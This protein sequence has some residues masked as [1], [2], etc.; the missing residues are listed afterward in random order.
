M[1]YKTDITII[2]AGIIGLAIA[3]QVAENER[4]VYVLEKNDTFGQEISSRTS[5]VIHAGIYYPEG[6]LK[7]KTCV[8]GNA[9]LYELCDKYGIAHK[10]LGKIIIATNDVECEGLEML[11]QRGRKNG[12]K[13]LKLL[14][15]GELKRLEPNIEGIAALLSPS[16]G[17]IDSHALMKYFVEKAKDR[18]AKIA[19]RAKV[20]EIEKLNDGYKVTVKDPNGDFSFVTEVLIN[21][22]GLNSDKIAEMVGIDITKAGY[23]IHYCKGE[24]FSI[25]PNKHGLVKRLVYPAPN[26]KGAGLGIHITLDLEGKMRLGPNARYVD[27]IDYAVD[28]SQKQAFYHSVKRFLP[29]IEHLDLE[30]DFAGIRPKLQGMGEDFR[31]FVIKH[32]YERGLSGFINL[33]GIE[34]PGLTSSVAISKYVASL[35]KESIII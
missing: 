22:A 26:L 25:N 2:G 31:D 6:S 1:L 27:K 10:R 23:K 35:V 4:G 7:A 9:I 5:E 21:S 3:A 19:Y 29:F 13:D 8:E 28:E 34:S 12:A 24:Y 20:A 17:I 30:P 18:G 15:K 16:T 14:S 11:L 32:E 33:L